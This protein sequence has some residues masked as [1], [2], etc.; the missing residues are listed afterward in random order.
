MCIY[1]GIRSIPMHT[2]TSAH[3]GT[4]LSPELRQQPIKK[5]S[6]RSPL[7]INSRCEYIVLMSS[8]KGGYTHGNIQ[9]PVQLPKAR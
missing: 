7:H 5:I 3:F 4:E 2:V 1:T 9:L 6:Y 8:R